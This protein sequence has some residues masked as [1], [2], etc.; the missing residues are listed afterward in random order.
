MHSLDRSEML[1]PQGVDTQH[2]SIFKTSSSYRNDETYGLL[3]H[4]RTLSGKTSGT[5]AASCWLGITKYCLVRIIAKVQ[6][7]EVSE[8][9]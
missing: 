1:P 5:D 3:G 7:P 6:G 9:A 8:P 4:Q 2:R